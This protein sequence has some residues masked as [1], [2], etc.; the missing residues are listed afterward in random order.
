LFELFV[1]ILIHLLP[2]AVIA[3]IGCWLNHRFEIRITI[4]P[5]LATGFEDQGPVFAK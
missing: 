4:K 3:L 5:R 2:Q 1:G